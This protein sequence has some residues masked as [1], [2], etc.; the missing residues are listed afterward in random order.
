MPILTA[1]LTI[2]LAFFALGAIQAPPQELKGEADA[3]DNKITGA[4][5]PTTDS[6]IGGV[7]VEFPTGAVYTGDFEGYRFNGY[8][9]FEGEDTNEQGETVTWRYEGTFVNGRLSGQGSYIDALGS[10]QGM[11]QNSIPEGKGTYTSVSG[12]TYEGEFQAGCMTGWGTVTL[13]DGT[14]TSGQFE[15]GLQV[16]GR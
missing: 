6:F 2:A 14:S 13:A 12:W 15:D 3:R 4:Y 1:L 5:D 7:K 8:G 10:Y 11:F 9:V 16:S